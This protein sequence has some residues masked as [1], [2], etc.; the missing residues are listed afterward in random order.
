MAHT[1]YTTTKHPRSGKT[2]AVEVAVLT[3]EDETDIIETVIARVAGPLHYS[4]P[5]DPTDPDSLRDY[6]NSQDDQDCR[7]D[8]VW[9]RREIERAEA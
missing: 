5:T 9:L 3:G 4:D 1:E 2:Y 7:D 6:I 8:A